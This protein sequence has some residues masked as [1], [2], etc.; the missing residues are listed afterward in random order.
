M[1]IFLRPQ[2]KVDDSLRHMSRTTTD[3][4]LQFYLNNVGISN[5]Q[6]PEGIIAKYNAEINDFVKEQKV[7][8]GHLK[9]FTKYVHAIVPM[10][11]QESRYY[12]EFAEF[13]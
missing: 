6:Q 1:Q 10:K 11:E 12:R 4:V 8:L 3:K 13:L 7:L 9:N 5:V 2:G